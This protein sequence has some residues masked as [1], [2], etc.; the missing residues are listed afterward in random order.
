MTSLSASLGQ[1]RVQ[2]DPPRGQGRPVHSRRPLP[3]QPASRHPSHGGTRTRG[4]HP[5]VVDRRFPMGRIRSRPRLYLHQPLDL[6]GKYLCIP[7]HMY[8]LYRPL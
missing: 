7:I 2:R 8:V 6:R 3:G 5:N 4:Q 1:H